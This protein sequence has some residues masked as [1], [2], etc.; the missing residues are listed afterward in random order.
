MEREVIF[1]TQL[2]VRETRDWTAPTD[3]PRQPRVLLTASFL[4]ARCS[5]DPLWDAYRHCDKV[6]QRARMQFCEERPDQWTNVLLDKDLVQAWP[7]LHIVHVMLHESW[8]A[9]WEN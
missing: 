4:Y 1:V 8:Q 7:R 9:V 2:G 5:A 3:H 6:P